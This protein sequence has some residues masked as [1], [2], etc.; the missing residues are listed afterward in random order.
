MYYLPILINNRKYSILSLKQEKDCDTNESDFI[1]PVEEHGRPELIR[2]LPNLRATSE[3][4][5]HDDINN[6]V[7]SI[8]SCKYEEKEG[9]ADLLK[10]VFEENTK[11]NNYPSNEFNFDFISISQDDS[12]I[13]ISSDN[14]RNK[15]K[16][17]LL[18]I[19]L[20][21]SCEDGK[22]ELYNTMLYFHL[23]PKKS[24][25]EV[26]LDFGSEASQAAFLEGSEFKKIHLIENAK[27]INS[28]VAKGYETTPI[29]NF[30]QFDDD[31]NTLFKTIFYVENEYNRPLFLSEKNE[32]DSLKSDKKFRLL[33]NIKIALLDEKEDR[34][35]VLI[36][37]RK[38][39]LEFI[40][41]IIKAIVGEHNNQHIGIQLKL[42]VPN[43]MG[44][45]TI[46]LLIQNIN[47]ELL[48][49][50]YLGEF[51]H[52]EITPISESD[53]SFAGY[54]DDKQIKKHKTFLT[55]DAGKGTMDY[56]VCQ[57]DES[58]HIESLYQNGFIGAGNALTYAL[59]DHVCAVIVGSS[60]S[61]K[62]KNLMKQILMNKQTDQKGLRDL[63]TALENIKRDYSNKFNAESNLQRCNELHAK[64]QSHEDELTAGGLAT[65]L[66]AIGNGSL[67]DQYSIIHKMCYDICSKLVLSL[68]GIIK[69]QSS[70]RWKLWK[71]FGKQNKINIDE[72]I[73]TGRAF[74]FPL[75]QKTLEKLF[76]EKWGETVTITSLPNSKSL[77][78]RGA[79][80]LNLSVNFNC[81]LPSKP[82][83]YK[84]KKKLDNTNF[85]FN[86]EDAFNID[87]DFINQGTDI[88]LNSVI[89]FNGQEW[90]VRGLSPQTTGELYFTGNQPILRHEKSIDPLEPKV[91]IRENSLAFESKFPIYNKDT[92]SNNITLF[93]IDNL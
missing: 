58:G 75:L 53:A 88:N 39:I 91:M 42:L 5:T 22:I 62:R 2:L 45:K 1:I 61:R 82:Q 31:D 34:R 69:M 20:N 55:I 78:L 13:I 30:L 24:F 92:D 40:E 8:S 74:R 14:T 80:G 85:D 3:N 25:Y 35:K 37:Y 9:L 50:D 89:L 33:P 23:I 73:L 87:E 41:T 48:L 12:G 60:D 17:I 57:T 44:I 72:I 49:N 54:V 63:H 43:V 4:G 6:V 28:S 56:S 46:N 7:L 84:N 81:G 59:F 18:E 67:G 26:S 90:K 16:A 79:L 10:L 93:N 51:V 70:N 66:N 52:L 19:V 32:D 15:Y 83:I 11:S 64:T 38:A 36:V 68:D 77:C 65:I 21:K 27:Q 76:K 47:D 29:Q 71:R 86:F